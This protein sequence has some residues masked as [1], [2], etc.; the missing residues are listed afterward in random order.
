MP[1][2]RRKNLY[3]GSYWEPKPA[4]IDLP[5]TITNLQTLLAAGASPKP[6]YTHQQIK[7]WAS[8]FWWE[9]REGSLAEHNDPSLKGA[10]DLAQDVEMQWDMYLA[11]TYS[12]QELQELDF[13]KVELPKGWFV[14][15]LLR[16]DEL[17]YK[18]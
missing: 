14:D 6:L 8:R 10:I 4:P 7:E 2:S 3:L 11:N 17:G 18:A 9:K 12:L 1:M 5:L 13:S 16:L 15:W